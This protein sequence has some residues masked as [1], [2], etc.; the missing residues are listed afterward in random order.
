MNRRKFLATSGV[1]LTTA[2]AGCYGTPSGKFRMTDVGLSE[3]ENSV[4]AFVEVENITESKHGFTGF[5]APYDT[6]GVR[7]SKWCFVETGPDSPVR[8]GRR[9]RLYAPYEAGDNHWFDS[10]D[11][12][13]VVDAYTARFRFSNSSPEPIGPDYSQDDVGDVITKPEKS[14][15]F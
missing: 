6:D 1:V 13:Q 11:V 10:N 2:L 12:G 7:L 15:W 14:G 9:T 3:Q 5:L 8:P 4:A